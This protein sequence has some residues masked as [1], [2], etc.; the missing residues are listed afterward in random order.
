MET[1]LWTFETAGSSF[2]VLATGLYEAVWNLD[3]WFGTKERSEI[4]QIKITNIKNGSSQLINK[5]I[6]P[7]VLKT[8]NKEILS[9]E[10][11]KLEI[12]GLSNYKGFSCFMDSVLVPILVIDSKLRDDILN[13]S[14]TED[15]ALKVKQSLIDLKN[16]IEKGNNQNCSLLINILKNCENFKEMMSGEQQDDH[17]FLVRLLQLFKIEPTNVKEQYYTWDI[18]D[19]WRLK[20]DR[21]IK[22]GILEINLLEYPENGNIL[23]VYQQGVF[24]DFSNSP[25]N[26]KP[27][28]GDADKGELDRVDYTYSV[29]RIMN[30]DYLIFHTSRKMFN[31]KLKVQITIPQTI[32]NIENGK[33]YSL[34]II[35]VHIG[36]S[37]GGHYISFFK[38]NDKWYLYDD[39]NSKIIEIDFEKY[40]STIY[41]NSSMIFYF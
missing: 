21:D 16:N 10:T 23:E 22:Y 36:G 41:T 28:K 12:S 25:I 37:Q 20:N 27:F 18:K 9:F 8:V 30:S 39:L 17:E 19:K 34:S 32:K 2:N 26:E 15:C 40:K 7:E 1:L 6:Q 31:S 5:N 38:Y 35:T 3:S 13:S 11:K 24:S 33:E 4:E 14:S 29:N